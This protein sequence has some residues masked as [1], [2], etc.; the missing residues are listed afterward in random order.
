[1]DYFL[2]SVLIG[3]SLAS[4]IGPISILCV[5]QT[6]AYGYKVG[7]VATLGATTADAFYAAV[8]AYGLTMI[9]GFLVENQFFLR[10]V[11]GL[12]LLYLGAKTIIS[13]MP[14]A[15]NA[16]MKRRNLLAN[17]LTITF[18]TISNPLTIILFLSVF[19]GF[20]FAQG[21]EINPFF[22]TLGIAIGS[23]LA[24]VVLLCAAVILKKKASDKALEIFH[25]L[26]GFMIC[27]FA[28]YAFFGA[29]YH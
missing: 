21:E 23:M 15:N 14:K 8:A 16:A 17:Y 9:S 5:R 28:L 2:Q 1:M 27:G 7:F 3:F 25:T 29:F 6:I 11:G 10:I 18:L 13:K 19:T 26:S 4:V 24:Y 20:G 12:F 22:V